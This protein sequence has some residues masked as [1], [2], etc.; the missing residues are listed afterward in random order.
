MA[1]ISS[2]DISN[3]LYNLLRR[4]GIETLDQLAAYSLK[5]IKRWS[6]CGRSTWR[7]IEDV[8]SDYGLRL[9]EDEHPGDTKAERKKEIIRLIKY[10]KR[11]VRQ[12]QSELLSL[13]T[14]PSNVDIKCP[15]C[16]NGWNR[17]KAEYGGYCGQHRPDMPRCTDKG[18][19]GKPCRNPVYHLDVCYRHFQRK[20]AHIWDRD[21][22]CER[23]GME[24]DLIWHRRDRLKEVCSAVAQGETQ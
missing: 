19:H 8:L 20:F 23:C 7:E 21:D 11:R 16:I 13:D 2:I 15:K 3:R 4:Q 14:T 6:N 17:G 12:L 5:D 22:R 10:H 24:T 1:T 18:K 9:S